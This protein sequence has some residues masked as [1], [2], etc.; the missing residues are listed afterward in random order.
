MAG[1]R[2]TVTLML[3]HNRVK[4]AIR[5]H[6]EPV[7]VGDSSVDYV[8]GSCGV[9]LCVGMREGDLAGLAFT[10]ECGA[11]SRVP[12]PDLWR[13]EGAF[14]GASQMAWA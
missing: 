14:E 12:W 7:F 1:E 4:D 13:R 2:K 10:C 6:G 5:A 8:C 3:L 11:S 9:P